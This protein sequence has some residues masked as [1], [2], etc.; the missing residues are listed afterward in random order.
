MQTVPDPAVVLAPLGSTHPRHVS[1]GA[2]PCDP[3]LWDPVFEAR[4][5]LLPQRASF[6]KASWKFF[7]LA[8]KGRE[9]AF[10]SWDRAWGKRAERPRAPGGEDFQVSTRG[11]GGIATAGDN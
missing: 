3:G 9:G 10:F 1:A 6:A 4:L 7:L 11:G 8:A 5:M 2:E